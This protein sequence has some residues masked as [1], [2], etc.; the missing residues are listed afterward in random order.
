MAWLLNYIYGMSLPGSVTIG[1]LYLS[2]INEICVI[3]P[4]VFH[5][6][7]LMY[8][9]TF[10]VVFDHGRRGKCNMGGPIGKK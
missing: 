6:V 7:V 5:Y 9:C 8:G 1:I 2:R 3:Q 4:A 10:N